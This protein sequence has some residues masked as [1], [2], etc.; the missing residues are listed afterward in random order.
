MN[1][2]MTTVIFLMVFLIQSTQNQDTEAMQLKLDEIVC[3]TQGAHN[4]LLDLE[5]LDQSARCL[6]QAISNSR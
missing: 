4:T 6:S 1:T 2:N 3:A 5:E